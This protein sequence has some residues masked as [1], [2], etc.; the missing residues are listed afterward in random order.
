M[1]IAQ[2]LAAALAMS[3]SAAVSATDAIRSGYGRVR[4]L[5]NFKF[6]KYR[7]SRHRA[8]ANGNLWSDDGCTQSSRKDGLPRGYPG[9]KLARKAMLKQVAVKHP[10]GLRLDGVTI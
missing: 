1:K 7:P 10:R 5:P 2:I 8:R 6:E 9:A 3:A 4:N